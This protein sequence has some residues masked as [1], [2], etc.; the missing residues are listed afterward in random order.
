MR[1]AL[2]EE[3]ILTVLG[4]GMNLV[5]ISGEA[6]KMDDVCFGYGASEADNSLTDLKFLEIH[7]VNRIDLG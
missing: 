1:H 3:S 7:P 5:E 2:P 4:V 6:G